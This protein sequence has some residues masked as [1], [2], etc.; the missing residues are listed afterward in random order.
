MFY[1]IYM[2]IACLYVSFLRVSRNALFRDVCL[3]LTGGDQQGNPGDS[4]VYSV[5]VWSVDEWTR[6]SVPTSIPAR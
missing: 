4:T 2:F 5:C 6:G 1:M 3:C